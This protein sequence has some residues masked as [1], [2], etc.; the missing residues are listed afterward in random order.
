MSK[1]LT[2]SDILGWDLRNW[3][4]ALKYWKNKIPEN[5]N[6]N[7]LEI[8]ANKGGIS[9]WLASMGYNVICSDVKPVSDEVKHWHKQ[10][11]LKGSISYEVI[12]AV[13]IPYA[14]YFDVII[15]KSVLGGVSRRGHS[16][17]LSETIFQIKKALKPSG[18]FLFAE[19]LTGTKLHAFLRETFKKDVKDNWNYIHVEQMKEILKDFKE[20]SYE[21][22]GFAGA[23]GLYEPFRNVLGSID[24]ILF[25][26]LP[27]NWHYIVYGYAKK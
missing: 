17:K 6:L 9:L 11:N 25:K 10:F 4:R 20:S 7:C 26:T 22:T 3:S 5:T 2:D 13:N 1:P 12:D 18:V 23:F 27:A 16:E 14:D 19:N 15:L 21:T 24:G 8:G